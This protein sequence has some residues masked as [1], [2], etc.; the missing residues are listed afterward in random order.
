MSPP[1]VKNHLDV[2]Q[3]KKLLAALIRPGSVSPYD[4]VEWVDQMVNEAYTAGRKAKN[5]A[6]HYEQV[7]EQA[8]VA[9]E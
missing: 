5:F 2:E 8:K 3:K 7:K 9:T 1:P 6:K 4:L